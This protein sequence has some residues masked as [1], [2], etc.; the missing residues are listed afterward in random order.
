MPHGDLRGVL[1]GSRAGRL[2]E[3][4]LFVSG[5]PGLLS[6]VALG[7]PS[8]SPLDLTGH[9]Q[10]EEGSVKLLREVGCS[11]GQSQDPCA[12]STPDTEPFPPRWATWLGTQAFLGELGLNPAPA[13]VLGDRGLMTE[14]TEPQFLYL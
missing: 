10:V 12:H 8:C 2:P 3:P 9:T 1:G 4:P 5:I 7:H 13:D 14:L 6:D 11:K